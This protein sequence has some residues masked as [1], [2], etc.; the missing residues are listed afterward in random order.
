MNVKKN[1]ILLITTKGC[2]GCAI[3]KENIKLAI[4]QSSKNIELEV[5]DKDEVKKDFVIANK[6]K[7]FPTTFYLINERVV[8][9]SIGSYPAPVYLRWIDIYF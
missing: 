9:K 1:K 7:D 8:H 4:T 6:I 5:V 2:E 3:A